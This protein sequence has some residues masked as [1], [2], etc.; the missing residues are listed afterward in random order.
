MQSYMNKL[1]INHNKIGKNHY[2][3]DFKGVFIYLCLLHVTLQDSTITFLT[4][5]GIHAFI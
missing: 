4:G 5:G 1:A 2:H 3:I